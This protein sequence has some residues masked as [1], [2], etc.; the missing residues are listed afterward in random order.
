MRSRC[1]IAFPEDWFR[2][3][4]S[5]EGVPFDYLVPDERMLPRKQIINSG[6]TGQQRKDETIRFFQVDR[7]WIRALAC[8]AF[9]VGLHDGGAMVIDEK[10]NE[11]C[12]AIPD[13]RGFLLRSS[14][15]SDWP[16]LQIVLAPK[17]VDGHIVRRLSAE[18]ELRL[19]P[20]ATSSV[21]IG[22]PRETLH[23]EWPPSANWTKYKSQPASALAKDC[24]CTG[25]EL[26]FQLK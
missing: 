15:V 13:Q 9:S 1:L 8:G 11:L 19:F 17:V 21:T 3:L 25:D 22:L 14:I 12:S 10:R 26:K 23:C 5:L 16:E 18:V 20:A 7:A 24:L 2:R 6:A 4:I